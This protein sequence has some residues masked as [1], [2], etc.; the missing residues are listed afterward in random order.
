MDRLEKLSTLGELLAGIVHDIN[1][2]VGLVVGNLAHAQTY[3]EQLLLI[4]QL[5]QQAC[6]EPP[7]ELAAAMEAAE[8]DYIIEDLPK[9]LKACQFGAERLKR[10]A[11]AL[12]TVARPE[13]DIPQVVNPQT[14]IEN[15]LT[16]LN[17]RLLNKRNHVPIHIRR[18]FHAEGVVY[19]P[20]GLLE[21]AVMNL[22]ANAI[23]A[24]ETGCSAAEGPEITLTTSLTYPAS[25]NPNSP[26]RSPNNGALYRIEIADNGPGIPPAV[27]DRLFVEAVT[28]KPCDQ[29]TGL[30]LTIVQNLVEQL[31]GKVQVH[32][33]PTGGACFVLEFPCQ[34]A[35]KVLPT[36]P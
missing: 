30:G 34:A 8:L 31:G 21:R 32:S 16:I 28:T 17:H 23:D 5:Y 24:L 15:A 19:G 18:E 13:E 10:L 4:I 33:S 35:P 2:P 7:A 25:G 12:R 36:A 29:G 3:V 11:L 27:L 26:H 20:P 9:T 22:V 1:N 6:P 14:A